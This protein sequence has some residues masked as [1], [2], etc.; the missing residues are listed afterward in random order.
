M[1]ALVIWTILLGGP[2][3]GQD[4]LPILRDLL[5]RGEVDSLLA[6]GKQE[7]GSAD[8]SPLHRSRLLEIIGEQFH[9][10][11]DIGEAKH[12]WDEA[13]AIRQRSYGDSSVE[14]AVGYAFIAR[15]HNYMASPQ[16]DHCAAALVEAARAR[17]LM[18]GHG[19][20]DPWERSLLLREYGYAFKVVRVHKMEDSLRLRTTRSYYQ[21]ALRSAVRARDTAW[22]AQ[23]THDIGNTYTDEAG[24][25]ASLRPRARIAVLVD[26]ARNCYGRSVELMTR[27]GYGTTRAV[28]MDHYTTA[29]L[30]SNAYGADSCAQ[31]IHSFDAA[32]SVMHRQAGV[33][34]P[35]HPLR[36]EPRIK[37]PA[38]MV[39]LLFQRAWTL[40]RCDE[41]SPGNQL[42]SAISSLEAAIPYWEQLLR[43]YRSRDIEKVIGS[44]GHFPF[45]PGSEM[46]LRRYIRRGD[47]E[48]LQRSLIWSERNRGA[49][50]Q[51]KRLLAGLPPSQVNDGALLPS[52]L[53]AAAG[54]VV[55][56][57]NHP[58]FN[59]VF[60]VDEKGLSVTELE[61]MPADLDRSTGRF[62][63]FTIDR[64][65][66]SPERYAQ[67]SYAWY[68]RLLKPVLDHRHVRELVIVPYGSLALL[69][70]EA[71]CTSPQAREWSEAAFLGR[72]YTVRY[73]RSV[74]EA[75]MV[76]TVCP[77]D[78]PF[79]ATA[80]VD[81]LAD[82]P[83]AK[84]LAEKLHAGSRSG[85]LDNDLTATELIGALAK[86][87]LIHLATHG[88][89]PAVPDAVPSLL[90]SDGAWPTTALQEAVSH[91]TLAVLSTCS[92][93]SGRNYQGEGVMSIAHAFLGAGTKSVVHTLW[94][95]DDRSTSEI[96]QDFYVGLEDDLPASEALAKA[97]LDFIARHAHDGLADP[98]Y[99]SGIVLT[100]TDVVL[101]SEPRSDWWYATAALPL[102]AGGYILSKRRS[103]AR[104]WGET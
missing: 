46:Y 30:Y 92:S 5:V 95:V 65:G 26:S 69:P 17:R 4:P 86:S 85:A 96:L 9:Q 42:D 44:Y 77:R 102:L 40:R 61:M 39:E 2:A 56:A 54:S 22:I 99:W 38:Q 34:A 88:V 98:F 64:Q 43:D 24:A 55:I 10:L 13:L 62:N 23:I 11:S 63:E 79:L 47:P 68:A 37:D 31:A 101:Q 15:Y 70:F 33:R 80:D 53:V 75:L 100:G 84:S 57:F 7:L 48:D 27:A 45:R 93:G 60:V 14:A 18:N 35:F 28:M 82:L 19:S 1:R 59:G 89:N 50:L 58:A 32:L 51:R 87:G 67:E 83:F 52:A 21:D 90:L 49:S 103:R 71:L 74:A 20:M 29:L 36:Y 94:P 8:L 41:T 78:K 12:Y 97:K 73:A 66:W 16:L 6:L 104:A 81:S 3:Y 91:R 76:K 72:Q 25:Y